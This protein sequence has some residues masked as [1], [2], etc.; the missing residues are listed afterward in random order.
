[1]TDPELDGVRVA[2]G[3]A[4]EPDRPLTYSRRGL[5]ERAALGALAAFAV[6]AGSPGIARARSEP[7]PCRVRC[8]PVSR[9]GC[10]CGGHLYR[11]SGCR[12]SFHA[13]IEG[14]PFTWIC[15]R[16]HC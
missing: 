7:P 4:E 15:L 14:K 16:R 5:L 11:C 3:P 8:S 2:E 10:A 13:C 12:R 1:M 6:V 9:T